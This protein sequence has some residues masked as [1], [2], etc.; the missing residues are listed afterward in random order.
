MMRMWTI[1]KLHHHVH[2][3]VVVAA[4]VAVAEDHSNAKVGAVAEVAAANAKQQ[5]DEPVVVEAKDAVAVV[6][7]IM[8]VAIIT[9][10]GQIITVEA[11]AE[12]TK[13]D[14]HR[15]VTHPIWDMWEALK[16]PF[17]KKCKV[18]QQE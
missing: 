9:T 7:A 8:A 11:E 18:M 13:E 4:A 16:C 2:H 12:D 1:S 3:D 15:A 6:V 17:E 14:C 10:P 5:L